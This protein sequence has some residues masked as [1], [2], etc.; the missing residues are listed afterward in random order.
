MFNRLGISAF[1]L[2]YRVP[3]RPEKEGL[4][5]WWAAL[6]DAQR[7]ISYVRHGALLN[8]WDKQG[9]FI[10]ANRIGLIGFFAGGHLT[11]HV[12]TSWTTPAYK[13]VDS[14]DKTSS[15]PDFAIFGYPWRLLPDNKPFGWGEAY[16]LADEFTGDE[17]FADHPVSLFIHNEDDTTAPVE[18]ALT[19]YTKLLTVANQQTNGR[20]KASSENSEL[21][22]QSSDTL[23]KSTLFIGNQGGHG[24][25]L[26][27]T[28]TTYLEICDW[29]KVA[30]RFLQTHGLVEG[31]PKAPSRDAMVTQNCEG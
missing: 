10:N 14:V 4:P 12:S 20:L 21:L 26:C 27:Q 15:R 8:N 11:A 23:P 16:R 17:R 30:Q 7:A 5:K 25:G 6:Q 2:K 9:A 1:V 22:A 28:K 13:P 31:W 19:Y 29:P 3:T 24:F 18:G